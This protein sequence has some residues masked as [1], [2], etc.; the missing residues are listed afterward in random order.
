MK[1]SLLKSRFNFCCSC[2]RNSSNRNEGFTL[3]EALVVVIM[4]GILAAIAGPGWLAY[5]NKRRV[6]TTRDDIY[7]AILQAQTQAKQKSVS[8]SVSFRTSTQPD[9]PGFL[10]W[11]V[12]PSA[13]A[14][15][16]WETAKSGTVEVDTACA[17]AVD[18][19]TDSTQKFEFDYKGNVTDNSMSTLYLASDTGNFTGDD[20]PTLRAVHMQTLIGA[21]RKVDQ[22]CL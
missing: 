12:Y 17:G 1:R 7:Q 3:L 4:V 11:S 9:T 15:T 20:D 21:I 6:V 2:L 16:A 14:S 19:I 13:A 5:L 22:Q 10:E 18:P 8:Y